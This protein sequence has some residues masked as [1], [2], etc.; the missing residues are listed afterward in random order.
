MSSIT[1][2]KNISKKIRK[3]I[4]DCSYN[5]GSSAAHIGGALS[6]TDI[7]ASIFY[8]EKK[9]KD[10]EFVLSKGHACLALYGTLNYFKII[11]KTKLNT[12]EKDKS[13]L[14]GHPVKNKKLSINFSTGSLGIGFSIANGVA[15][16]LK[17][18]LSKKKV[19]VVLGDGECNEGIVWEAAMFASKYKLNNLIALIDKNNFQQ[20]GNT[21]EIMDNLNLSKKW[22]AFGWDTTIID[23]HD[24]KKIIKA[25]NN[26]TKKPKMIICNTI[27]GK[28]VKFFEND[29]AWHHK[30]LTRDQYKEAL[31]QL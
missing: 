19:Y 3:I 5:A 12:F 30:I 28:G 15:L 17:K 7:I 2:L 8:F 20:T 23:G 16:A 25:I 18:K 1:V 11:S 26:K 24:H 13:D 6:M 14:P 31:N 27:K 10:F 22:L 21:K 9:K 29:N 4:L